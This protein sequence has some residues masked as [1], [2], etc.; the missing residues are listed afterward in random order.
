MKLAGARRALWKV[1]AI[2]AIDESRTNR[3]LGVLH[4]L[5]VGTTL[6]NRQ[7]ECAPLWHLFVVRHILTFGRL[8]FFDGSIS[9][10]SWECSRGSSFRYCAVVLLRLS[11]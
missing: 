2:E 1:V 7:L 8:A 6:R 10:R 5:P 11:V 4:R 3:A 9:M